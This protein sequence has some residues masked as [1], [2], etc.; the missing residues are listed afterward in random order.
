MNAARGDVDRARTDLAAFSRLVG[1]ELTGFQA[2]ALSLATRH[3]V[4]L[5]P[6]QTGKSWSL[7]TLTAWWLFRQPRQE[8]LVL[9]AR[10]DT[11]KNLLKAV[12]QVAGKHGGAGAT[13]A[14]HSGKP[15]T[16]GNYLHIAHGQRAGQVLSATGRVVC[17][18]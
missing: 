18:G 12:R 16:A 6:R 3:T 11:A 8:V 13:P 14:A 2:E 17:T 10:E 15:P 5:A 1:R 4:L 9:S 7:A